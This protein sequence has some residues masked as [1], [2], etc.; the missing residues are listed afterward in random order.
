MGTWIVLPGFTYSHHPIW[1]PLSVPHFLLSL[2]L[3]SLGRSTLNH[4]PLSRFRSQTV[5]TL[6][7]QPAFLSPMRLI[8]SFTLFPENARTWNHLTL[9][10]LV[11]FNV[12]LACGV[13]FILLISSTRLQLFY[14]LRVHL[15]LLIYILS[16][17]F[18]FYSYLSYPP[19]EITYISLKFYL[20][21][22]L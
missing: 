14:T 19:S 2:F 17:L 21:Y 7:L 9:S 6:K 8:E 18:F 5:V 1:C 11:F 3:P 16:F 22:F 20:P 10:F 13:N 15:Y 4:F 12:M